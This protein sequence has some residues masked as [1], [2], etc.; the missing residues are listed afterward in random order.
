MKRLSI[1]ISLVALVGLTFVSPVVA[2]PPGN[3]LY[4]NRE[5]IAALPFNASVDTTEATTD[6]DDA[7]AN[8][9]CGAPATD[10]SVWYEFTPAADTGVIV[11]V[12][13]SS[14]SAGVLVATGSP[15][16]FSIVT[17]APGA[18][19]FFAAAGET[20]A[21]LA[22]DDQFDGG[23]NGGT[24]NITVAEIPPPPEIDVTVNPIGQFNARTGTATIS[25]SVTCSSDASFAFIDVSLRQTVGRFFVNGFG[26]MEVFCDGSTQPWSVEVFPDGGQFKGGRTA[27]VTFAIACGIFDCGFD[28]EERIVR[29]RR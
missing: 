14:Y 27:S 29:L 17:C 25:G 22:I 1:S 13:S 20:Y 24:L 16:S 4:A 21:I 3:D 2:A 5:T 9:T 26:G 18:V 6:A 10:A 7:D 8:S 11:D 12:S 28:F 23:G 19:G 15:G